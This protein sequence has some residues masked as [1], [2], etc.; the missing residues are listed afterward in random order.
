MQRRLACYA[1]LSV[2]VHSV[3]GVGGEGKEGANKMFNKNVH[4]PLASVALTHSVGSMESAG[5]ENTAV[6]VSVKA[7]Q[8]EKEETDPT[9]IDQKHEEGDGSAGK[10]KTASDDDGFDGKEG[11][12]DAAAAMPRRGEA[13]HASAVQTHGKTHPTHPSTHT[14]TRRMGRHTHT[15]SFTQS[16]SHMTASAKA[17]RGGETGLAFAGQRTGEDDGSVGN[18]N[19]SPFTGTGADAEKL[20]DVVK[21]V[22]KAAATAS[23]ETRRLENSL[24]SYQEDVVKV[25]ET[26]N[27]VDDA[28]KKL[29]QRYFEDLERQERER[30]EMLDVKV[31]HH[32]SLV[33]ARALLAAAVSS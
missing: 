3:D 12:E 8:P 7:T 11:G 32:S 26:I 25:K 21:K 29:R 28:G 31:P 1:L 6:D 10:K 30:V 2:I 18:K 13:N 20:M 9:S 16:A 33:E 17:L 15:P 27:N 22:G 5:N 4:S 14:H 19:T 23:E 24:K